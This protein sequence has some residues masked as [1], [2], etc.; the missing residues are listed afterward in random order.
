M[1]LLIAAAVST[2]VAAICFVKGSATFAVGQRTETGQSNAEI[3]F[4]A[5]S[6]SGAAAV[7]FAVGTLIASY[8]R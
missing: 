8:Q 3:A 6:G 5:S 4:G 7:S 1:K 2:G